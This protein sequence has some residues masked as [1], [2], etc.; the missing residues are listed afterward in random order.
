MRQ[1]LMPL[2]PG[3]RLRHY[4]I[5]APLGAG[6]M[7]EVYRAHDASLE[8]DVAV[9][10]LPERVAGSADALARF[11]REAKAVAA[12][13]HPNI[14]AIHE[15]G[16]QDE[17][18]YAVTELLE[19]ETL[20]H[21]L[22]QGAL[23]QR[24]A[25]E[26]AVQIANGLGAAHA[27]GIVHRD[28]KPENVF[29]T[30]DGRLKILDFGL[31]ALQTASDPDS[32]SSPTVG[33]FTNPGAVVGTVGYMSP[34]Q[35][36][37]GRIDARTD[38]FALGA[39][40]YEMLSG[41][42]AFQRDTAAETMTAILKDD[43]ADIQASGRQ[44]P[45]GLERL[46]RCC[47]EKNEEERLQSA[48]DV[49]IALEAVSGSDVSSA[50]FPAQPRRSQRSALVAAALLLAGA[51]IGAFAAHGL[52]SGTTKTAELP[53]YQA[54]T[55]RRGRVDEARFSSDGQTVVYSAVWDSEPLRVFT[56]R[57]DAR[58]ADSPPVV[59][60]AL[61]GLSRSGELAVA[62]RPS[63][64]HLTKRGTLAQ[65]S[66]GG[67]APRELLE[68]VR[69]ADW[70]P[71]GRLAAVRAIGGHW[72]LEFPIGTVVY[73][74]A[75]WL[76][77]PRFAPKGDS[78][79]FHEHPLHGD[80]RGWPA[81][82]DLRT[83]AKR[84]L[85]PEFDSLS[86]LAWRPDGSEVCFAS[87]SSL[88]CVAPDGRPPRRVLQAATRLILHDIAADGRVLAT[89]YTLK[90]GM[91]ASAGASE[92]DL[93][94]EF[95]IPI[96]LDLSRRQVLFETLSYGVY[97]RGLDKSPPVRLG[98]GIPVGLS[99]D[100]KQVL[101]IVPGVPTELVVLPA[102]AGETRTLPRGKLANHGW[103]AWL[104]DGK[105]VV[106]SGTEPDHGSRLYRQDIASGE[107]RPLTA[108]GVRLVPYSGR[109]VSPDGRFVTAIGP[110]QKA[111]LYPLAGG[112]P[113]ELVGL[114]DDLVPV[115]WTDSPT[116][117]FARPWSISRISPLYRVDLAGGSRKLVKE[118]GPEDPS[119]APVVLTLTVSADG[120]V[121]AYNY[122][123]IDSDLFLV[124]GVF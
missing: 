115:G 60:G 31:A 8:R 53:Q 59:E 118:L 35:V 107:P 25:V 58:R 99:P 81:L 75:G 65:A 78:I 34:E 112:E 80:D 32:T 110:D 120:R 15:F 29:L 70:S 124:S 23:P 123:R 4:E 95:S 94:W 12:L 63:F 47:L 86:G 48:R 37:G 85:A 109:A 79:A 51:A 40:L 54:L 102:G 7:G 41:R 20:R 44:L 50:L 108:G 82:V 30:R 114:G 72:R 61:F 39:V 76:S 104:P 100:G 68:G 2:A 105:S 87:V 106:V 122:S 119:G 21:R 26:Y 101:T 42:R 38:I 74:T 33:R 18:A 1:P 27:K 83:G 6:G 66:I 91:M 19:G 10:V 88:R 111:A 45:V 64:D 116:A 28:L 56:A 9:K 5:V 121:Y 17:T 77:A 73:E 89:S 57:L 67:G 93:S 43:V 92:V 62:V 24:K 90:G 52:W 84:N 49:A 113:R 117:L 36:R 14:L 13:S 55:A 98:E 96:D 11:E 3:A 46:V 69:A 97:L 22:A 71:D 103:A 16:R